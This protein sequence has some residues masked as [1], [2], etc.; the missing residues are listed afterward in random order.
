M[1][2]AAAST[3][4]AGH[5]PASFEDYIVAQ[6]ALQAGCSNT[7][8]VPPPSSCPSYVQ[9][10]YAIAAWHPLTIVLGFMMIV[11]FLQLAFEARD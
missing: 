1:S 10:S 4:V 9:A 8:T 3:S 11:F 6:T 7:L 2:N 5:A